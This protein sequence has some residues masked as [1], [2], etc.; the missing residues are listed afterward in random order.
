MIAV[1]HASEALF[2]AASYDR[3]IDYLITGVVFAGMNDGMLAHLSV[4]TSAIP[5][6]QSRRGFDLPSCSA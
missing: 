5:L 4:Y 6:R 2:I 3:Y 1:E